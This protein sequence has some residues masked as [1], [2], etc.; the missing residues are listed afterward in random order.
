L[1]LSN[2]SIDGATVGKWAEKGLRS[3]QTLKSLNLSHNPIGDDGAEHLTK[4]LISSATIESLSLI[5]CEIWGRGCRSLS[6][7]LEH[8]RGLKSLFVDGDMEELAETVLKSLQSNKRLRYLWTDRH[9]YLIRKD[10]QWRQVEFFLRLNRGKRRIL[11]DD[12][13]VPMSLWSNVLEG[14]SGDPRL[15]YYLLRQKP[16]LVALSAL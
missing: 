11:E 2:N 6:S 15:M 10:R 16:E 8:M 3:N 4:L 12:S 7:G 9:A 1:D 5:D 13:L 14:V